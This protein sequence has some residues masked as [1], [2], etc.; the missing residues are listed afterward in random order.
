MIKQ[1]QGHPMK[2]EIIVSNGQS[3]D[4]GNIGHTRHRTKANK[5]KKQNLTQYDNTKTMSNT[6]CTKNRG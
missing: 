3:R 6:D 5:Y 1:I 2:K 4:I